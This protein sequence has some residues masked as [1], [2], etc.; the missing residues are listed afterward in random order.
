MR[1]VHELDVFPRHRSRSISPWRIRGRSVNR[2]IR[3]AHRHRSLRHDRHLVL[4]TL[5]SHLPA[6]LANLALP[7]LRLGEQTPAGAGAE[8]TAGGHGSSGPFAVGV[9]IGEMEAAS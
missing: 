1:L 9:T 5:P 8:R 4:L 3:A 7:A 2:L 6:R